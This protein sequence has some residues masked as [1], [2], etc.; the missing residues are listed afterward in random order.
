VTEE[1]GGQE[2][3]AALAATAAPV[4]EA[5]GTPGAVLQRKLDDRYY[6]YAFFCDYE[7]WNPDGIEDNWEGYAHVFHL[8]APPA[9]AKDTREPYP[10]AIQLHAYTAWGGWNIPYTWPSTHVCARLLD[11]HLTWWFGYNDHLPRID[12]ATKAPPPGRVVN[13]T[14]RRV[15]QVARWLAS[16]PA[17]VPFKVDPAQFCIL[18]GSMGGTGTHTIGVRNGDIFAAAFADEGIWNWALGE[19]WNNWHGNVVRI[20]GPHER[21]APTLICRQDRCAVRAHE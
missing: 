16:N 19:R 21:N 15:L 5:V 1:R 14:E 2:D 3:R 12:P 11:Y 9:G 6:L 13:F 7:I 17:N 20:F 10:A 18:G 8:R 4:E